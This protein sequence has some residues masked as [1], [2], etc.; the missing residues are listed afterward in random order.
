MGYLKKVL[1]PAERRELLT[2][3]EDYRTG[4]LPLIVPL[5]LLRYEIR[6]H[7][8]E[9]LADQLYFDPHPKELVLRNHV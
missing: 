7:G 5:T 9:Y 4:L 1:G 8:V 3:I 2:A 6:R